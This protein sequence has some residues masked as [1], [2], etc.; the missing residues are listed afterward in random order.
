VAGATGLDIFQ[1]LEKQGVTIVPQNGSGITEATDFVVYSTAIESDNPDIQKAKSLNIPLL[2]RAEMLA[3]LCEGKQIIAVAGTAGKSGDPPASSATPERLA[4][5]RT[6][7]MP[8]AIQAQSHYKDVENRIRSFN[9][10]AYDRSFIN[11]LC[12]S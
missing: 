2:H 6:A 4:D 11:L 12:V 5:H 8:S 9:S 3:K 7:A 10:M 1:T